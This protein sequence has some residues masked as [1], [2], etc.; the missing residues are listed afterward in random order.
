MVSGDNID[1]FVQDCS[2]SSVLA[3]KW[4]MGSSGEL[5]MGSWEGYFG[6]Y[7]LSCKEAREIDTKITL[8]WEHKVYHESTYIKYIFLT[9]HN[10]SIND[11][12]E[13]IFTHQPCVSRFTYCWW[14]HDQ[15]MMSQIHYV[16]SQI[17]YIEGLTLANMESYADII[18]INTNIWVR[19][20]NCGCPVTWFCYQLIA[21]PGNKT[22][23]V[24]WPNPYTYN[25]VRGWTL[26]W[27]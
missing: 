26:Q 10:E 14:L 25:C 22:A 17:H 11:D 9:Q 2:N 23:T 5:F 15:L 20:Q 27:L 3:M 1:G 19:S 21:K 18:L 24:S 6:V 7:F 16:M 8:E 12:K 4:C 13:M